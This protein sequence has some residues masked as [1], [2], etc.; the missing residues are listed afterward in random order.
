ML[1]IL[2]VVLTWRQFVVTDLSGQM[3]QCNGFWH[4]GG[5]ITA[6]AVQCR[7]RPACMALCGWAAHGGGGV[8]AS[9]GVC[10]GIYVF[11]IYFDS[12]EILR[13]ICV[14]FIHNHPLVL[15]HDNVQLWSK[16][17]TQ[18][19]EAAENLAWPTYSPGKS[20][21]LPCRW[22]C[23]VWSVSAYTTAC[24]RSCSHQ[25][26]GE[27]NHSECSMTSVSKTAYLR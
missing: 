4:F 8:M 13:C 2:I 10:Y 5:L 3:L 12:T 6:F 25:T 14:P 27:Q 21:P 16:Y 24:F 23:L 7:C 9:A 26:G 15:Q 19:L 20:L 1:F 11:F 18:L 22:A 17:C